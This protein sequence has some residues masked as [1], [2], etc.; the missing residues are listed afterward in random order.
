MGG[1]GNRGVGWGQVRPT[2]PQR[3]V[4]LR[5]RDRQPGGALRGGDLAHSRGRAEGAGIL[6][7]GASNDWQAVA[8]AFTLAAG[9]GRNPWGVEQT[10]QNYWGASLEGEQGQWHI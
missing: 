1:S 3:R 6:S 9:Q 10:E 7:G 8:S 2:A 4:A 5:Q